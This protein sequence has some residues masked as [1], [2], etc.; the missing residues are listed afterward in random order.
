MSLDWKNAMCNAVLHCINTIECSI[1]V[2]FR[3]HAA[4]SLVASLFFEGL[5]RIGLLYILFVHAPAI[6]SI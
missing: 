1:A 4:S 6:Y 5:A 3:N 2:I